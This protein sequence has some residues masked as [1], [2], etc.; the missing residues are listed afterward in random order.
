M[1]MNKHYRVLAA[2]VLF[3]VAGARSLRAEEISSLPAEPL[4][5]VR[6]MTWT[7]AFRLENAELA[8][9]VVPATGRIL[10]LG[11]GRTN[12]VLRCDPGAGGGA[13]WANYGGIWM[14]PMAQSRWTEF[15]EKD[16]PPPD[17]LRNAAWKA[18]A[19]T[20]ADG[21]CRCLLTHTFP[22][23]LGVKASRLV[24]VGPTGTVVTI[25]QELECVATATPPLTIWTVT[26]VQRPYWAVVPAGGRRGV[27]FMIANPQATNLVSRAGEMAVCNT[28]VGEYKIGSASA[29]WVAA[30]AGETIVLQR[31]SSDAADGEYPDGG[32][33]VELYSNSGLGYCEIETLSPE[34]RLH[35]GDVLRQTVCISLHAAGGRA[36]D[37]RTM[38]RRV[39]ELVSGR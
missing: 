25:R 18:H 27:R 33:R 35:S 5:P 14:W 6:F 17:F 29:S 31:V 28:R 26:Q 2:C 19:W 39:R 22:A 7:N 38:L 20:C 10:F 16:W 37:S 23:P 24:E 1:N 15:Q 34:R 21:A 12:N 32:N 4:A 13:D 30:L 11:G 9:V 3:A 8:V 36:L